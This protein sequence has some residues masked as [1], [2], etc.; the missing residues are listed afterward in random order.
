M[1]LNLIR[2]FLIWIHLYLSS[3]FSQK[4]GKIL[5]NPG[6]TITFKFKRKIDSLATVHLRLSE[7][8]ASAFHWNH[9]N[10]IMD[11]IFGQVSFFSKYRSYR[12]LNIVFYI[13]IF[14]FADFLVQLKPYFAFVI[15][16]CLALSQ[17]WHVMGWH[18]RVISVTIQIIR[19][20]YKIANDVVCV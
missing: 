13:C 1:A 7:L 8:H 15:G 17:H 2:M 18:L 14:I 11:I 5:K 20:R 4:S 10:F 6:K 16:D 12:L 3:S 19:T 9:R